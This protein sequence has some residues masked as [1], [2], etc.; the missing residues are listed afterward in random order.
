MY[1]CGWCS[2]SF[3]GNPRY[4]NIYCSRAC[5]AKAASDKKVERIC[6]VCGSTFLARVAGIKN[7]FC[8]P[9]CR[10]R[11]TYLRCGTP[12]I[13]GPRLEYYAESRFR[14]Y[15]LSPAQVAEMMENQ[16]GKCKICKCDIRE[17]Y[18][19]DHCKD[20][21]VVRGLLCPNNNLG[22]GLFQHD[23]D[24]LIEAANYLREFK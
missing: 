4:K 13:R 24:V 22:L 19:I 10:N 16:N 3:V 18:H 20:T 14:K 17:E 2:E 8:S 23:P 7:R 15:G 11:E 5:T 21:G 9:K 12:D 6:D 1:T